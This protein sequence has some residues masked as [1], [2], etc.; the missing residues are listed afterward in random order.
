MAPPSTS[1]RCHP[2]ENLDDDADVSANLRACRATIRLQTSFNLQCKVNSS[3]S[4]REATGCGRT[5]A[6]RQRRM[7]SLHVE[8]VCDES[9][10]SDDRSDT[11][12][13]EQEDCIDCIGT[14]VSG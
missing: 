1:A 5:E 13:E 3:V 12:L 6:P 8:R 7:T 4:I 14:Q 2:Y 9:E 10:T 11:Q